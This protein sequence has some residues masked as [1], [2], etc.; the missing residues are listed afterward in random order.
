MWFGPQMMEHDPA[1]LERATTETDENRIPYTWMRRGVHFFF[2]TYYWRPAL[3]TAPR[4]EGF[5]IVK[6]WDEHREAAELAS[7]V[8]H[9]RPRVC[10][11]FREVSDGVDLVF[12][13]DCNGDGSDHLSLAA[14]GLE[15]G[16][17]TF[18]DKPFASNYREAL[19]IRDLARHNGAPLL[20]LSILQ[21]N[22]ATARFARRLEEVGQVS[23]GSVTCFSTHPAAL[24]HAISIV[25]HVFGTGVE[26]VRA[27]RTPRHTTLHLDYGERPDRPAHGVTIECGV[28]RFRFTEMFATAYGPEG[29]IQGLVLDDFNASEGSARILELAREMVRTR[30]AS[31]LGNEMFAAIAVMEAARRAEAEG[32]EIRVAD[33]TGA[34]G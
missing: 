26:T 1:L 33:I 11:D 29:A 4:V 7:R 22:P 32:G 25:H 15:K 10:D 28:A 8:F 30:Q 21:T 16:I 23:F 2:Y 6:L 20:S 19:A 31:P 17:P 14:P 5:E 34:A 3:M 9:G 27:V 18:I 12:I 13:A 24:I